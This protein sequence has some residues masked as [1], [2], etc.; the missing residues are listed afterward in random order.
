MRR[1]DHGLDFARHPWPWID[2]PQALAGHVSAG[3][4][5]FVGGLQSARPIWP[6]PPG[7]INEA[8]PVTPEQRR[9]HADGGWP[10]R[11]CRR[12][13]SWRHGQ[14]VAALVLAE[15]EGVA[16]QV[17]GLGAIVAP[18]PPAIAISASAS[19]RP[20]SEQSWTVSTWPERMSWRTKSPL[21]R[22][23]AEI[24]GRRRAFLATA[25]LGQIDRLAE[26]ARRL[27]DQHDRVALA[28]EGDRGVT[29]SR[30]RGR[31]RRRSPG[32]AECPGRWSRCRA[33]RCRTRPGSRAPG[34]PR[35]CRAGSPTN[36][37]ITSGPLGI[38]EIEVVGD[39]E[40]QAAHRRDVA[41]GLG[42]RLLAAL[43]RIGLAIAR[44]RRRW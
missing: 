26:P 13:A 42:D 31:R 15:Q 18:M 22:S 14:H 34:R 8:P 9:R 3:N 7:R 37:P 24:D 20:P 23:G 28:L 30:R 6:A 44:R 11:E 25:D 38:A 12:P 4:Q 27:A 1:L 10:H 29:S 19:A 32:S 41:P 5:R 16:R 33:T 39:R 35:R 2:R 21:R 36:W 17:V 43:E 40:R